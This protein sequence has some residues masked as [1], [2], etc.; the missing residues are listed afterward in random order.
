MITG[1]DLKVE[2]VRARVTAQRLAEA[3][4]V[5]RQRI[6]SIEALAVVHADLAARYRGALASLTPEVEIPAAGVAS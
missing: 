2:R 6:S 1:M 4:D 5:S 3:L